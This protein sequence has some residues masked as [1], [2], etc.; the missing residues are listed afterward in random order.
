LW[1][2]NCFYFAKILLILSIFFTV[3]NHKVWFSYLCFQYHLFIIRNVGFRNPFFI[4]DRK[5][6]WTMVFNDFF[7]L[8]ENWI[9]VLESQRSVPLVFTTTHLNKLWHSLRLLACRPEH[10]DEIWK[11]LGYWGRSQSF[12]H[13][14]YFRLLCF[15]CILWSW[16]TNHGSQWLLWNKSST[17]IF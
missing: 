13:V 4:N 6:I 5:K 7:H 12:N 1:S 16:M 10:R 2:Y 17:G 11:N 8:K 9:I 14:L 3:L 15:T